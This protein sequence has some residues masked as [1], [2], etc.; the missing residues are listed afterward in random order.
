MDSTAKYIG[1]TINGR[2]YIERQL[3]EG[4][5][6]F[7]FKAYDTIREEYV[8]IKIIQKEAF[9]PNKWDRVTAR[10]FAEAKALAKLSELNHPNI[11]SFRNYGEFNGE[12]FIVMELLEDNTLSRRMIRKFTAAEAAA[13]LAPIA[14]G[15]YVAHGMG[16]IHR[17][18]K[19]SNIMF[20]KGRWV[21]TD[22][23]IAKD[24]DSE[25]GITLTEL[26]NSIGTPEYMSPEQCMAVKDLDGR[27]DEYSLGLI[28]YEMITG[29]KPFTADSRQML[30]LQHVYAEIPKPEGVSENVEHIL[31]KVLEKDPEKRYPTIKEFSAELKKLIDQQ[32]NADIEANSDVS[33]STIE[34]P[35]SGA[36]MIP[37][38]SSPDDV[39][40]DPDVQ[41]KKP[42]NNKFVVYIMILI[43]ILLVGCGGF[44]FFRK[45]FGTADF[46]IVQKAET[47]LLTD[48][49][50]F[51]PQF[52]DTVLPSETS[53]PD[54]GDMTFSFLAS[55]T[56]TAAAV[57]RNYNIKSSETPVPVDTDGVYIDSCSM[58]SYLK[59]GDQA[60]V[61]ITTGLL[62]RESPFGTPTGNQAFA[63]KKIDIISDPR[64]VDGV[65]WQKVNFIGYDGWCMEGKDGVYYLQK[66]D[67]DKTDSSDIN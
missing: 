8:A 10:F 4:G 5:M 47:P 20:H 15:L 13:I 3:G 29:T 48:T 42:L 23:G 34:N 17:D 24:L 50:T 1:K 67:S 54:T 38:V 58:K 26:G 7:V 19:P 45:N 43:I 65:V 9:A 16:I 46:R 41:N 56:P 30:P 21:L 2:Y 49:V 44:L 40:D 31:Y 35:V 52:T 32:P 25:D 60:E 62:I 14:D 63:G 66:V 12:P 55:E 6:A 39:R 28:F 51:V 11:V 61:V 64:C 27:S 59:K 36:E 37:E 53:A 33:V 22:F 18:V 57:N